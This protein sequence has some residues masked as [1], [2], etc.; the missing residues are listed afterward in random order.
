MICISLYLIPPDVRH[1]AVFNVMVSE[2]LFEVFSE[3]ESNKQQ[4]V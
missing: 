3:P 1:K 2:L 4:E